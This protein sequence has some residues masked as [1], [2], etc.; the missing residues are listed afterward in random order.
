MSN[1]NKS[2][3]DESEYTEG[4]TEYT[5][6]PGSDEPTVIESEEEREPGEKTKKKGVGNAILYMVVAVLL[7]VGLYKGYQMFVAN[8]SSNQPQQTNAAPVTPAKQ[9]PPSE[10]QLQA[11]ATQQQVAPVQQQV[12]VPSQNGPEALPNVGKAGNTPTVE[13]P[14][15]SQSPVEQSVPVQSPVE[16]V[17]AQSPVQ[18]SPVQ[19]Q[20]PVQSPVE[21]SPVVS[22]DPNS[23]IVSKSTTLPVSEE[24]NEEQKAA[25]DKLV[26]RVDGMED[27]VTNVNNTVNSVKDMVTDNTGKISSLDARVTKLEESLKSQQDNLAAAAA[28]VAEKKTTVKPVVKKKAVSGTTRKSHATRNSVQ[29]MSDEDRVVSKRKVSKSSHSG[30]SAA[31]SSRGS[32]GYD[33]QAVLPG[34]AWVKNPN[35]TTTTYSVGDMLPNGNKVGK[36]DPD[37]GIVDSVGRSWPK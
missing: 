15:V 13:Q 22:A 6:S 9:Q 7:G 18:Q 10:Q 27:S 33:I 25:I 2:E 20:V 30:S 19:S 21:Q 28:K 4:E 35:G 3:Y 14:P 17:P 32:Y 23:P 5:E 24:V 16:Q 26:E 8:P 36:I 1:K 12:S 37:G 31:S 29:I 34:R 11:P